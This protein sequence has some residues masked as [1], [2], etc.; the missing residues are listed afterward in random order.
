[1][2]LL[3]VLT[4]LPELVLTAA[5]W[6]LWGSIRWRPL[7]YQYGAFW[8]GLLRGWEAN[9]AAQPYVM[10][11]SYAFLHA[12]LGHLAGNMIGLA[13]LG[14][15]VT[16]R[17][18]ARNMLILYGA[19]A[20]GGAATFAGMTRGLAPM[21]GASGAIFGLAGAW[22]TL[23]IRKE[24]LQGQRLRQAMVPALR[25]ALV[26]ALVN[27]VF[28]IARD[29]HLA[30]EAHLGGFLTGALCALFLAAKQRAIGGG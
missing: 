27:L 12:G 29:G 30:W 22:I 14:P 2:L 10:F 20:V 16:E 18:G 7:S 23:K 21:V 26:L 24:H 19:A 28:W 13:W 15:L 6:G 1:M 3:I 9:Y 4:C 8:G 5:D 17:L 11:L 25:I